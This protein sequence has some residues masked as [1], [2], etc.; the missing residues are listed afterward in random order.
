M[1]I[2]LAIEADVRKTLLTIAKKNEINIP[3]YLEV[4]NKMPE[5]Y[6]TIEKTA[7]KNRNYIRSAQFV[8]QSYAKTLARASELN[9][10]MKLLIEELPDM[11]RRIISAEVDTDYPSI[12]TETMQ[13][14]YDT[15]FSINH[16]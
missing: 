4:I 7:S 10:I 12:D 6:W 3:V 15:V 11:N 5:E 9:E 14:R 13:Y 16:Y 8:V 2:R 1:E